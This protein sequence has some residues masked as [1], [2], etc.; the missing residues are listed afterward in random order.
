MCKDRKYYKDFCARITS[1]TR[2]SMSSG[3]TP[4]LTKCCHSAYCCALND[5][6]VTG[7]LEMAQTSVAAG[8]T[9]MHGMV[10]F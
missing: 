3:F 1:M 6:H 8:R 4:P 9:G 10:T 2:R 7:L 5:W